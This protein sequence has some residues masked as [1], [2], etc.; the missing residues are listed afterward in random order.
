MT[1]TIH[2][3]GHLNVIDHTAFPRE[4][5]EPSIKAGYACVQVHLNPAHPDTSLDQVP[6]WYIQ[7]IRELASAVW[8]AARPIGG[9]KGDAG[10]FVPADPMKALGEAL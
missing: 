6:L 5:L 3:R 8:S 7:T 4:F 1:P 9:P 2:Q 10:Y